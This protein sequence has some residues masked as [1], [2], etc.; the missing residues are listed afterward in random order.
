VRLERL[1]ETYW[2]ERDYDEAVRLYRRAW[3]ERP[4]PEISHAL[5]WLHSQRGEAG[6][7]LRACRQ[8]LRLPLSP[9]LREDLRQLERLLLHCAGRAEPTGTGKRR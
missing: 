5:A 9:A 8:T 2:V 7:A 6:P 4:S 3:S 1:A